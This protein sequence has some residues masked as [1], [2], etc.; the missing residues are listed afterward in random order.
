MS[1]DKLLILIHVTFV[2]GRVFVNTTV[3]ITVSS[4]ECRSLSPNLNI[5]FNF[6]NKT[7][8]YN[9][10][11]AECDVPKTGCYLVDQSL[12]KFYTVTFTGDGGLLIIIQDTN[13]TRGQY[14]CCE[15]FNKESCVSTEIGAQTQISSEIHSDRSIHVVNNFNEADNPRETR[16][17]YIFHTDHSHVNNAQPSVLI[18]SNVTPWIAIVLIV[19]ILAGVYLFRKR[20]TTLAK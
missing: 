7:S 10:L 14:T 3:N 9:R 6:K 17:E 18:A 20:R 8:N 2:S 5:Q 13:Q 4:I 12:G 15:T 1:M 11:I 16:T 19:A